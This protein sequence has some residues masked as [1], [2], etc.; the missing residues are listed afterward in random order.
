M[1]TIIKNN[2]HYGGPPGVGIH[3]VIQNAD[4]T[5]TIYLTNGTSYTT[6]PLI[7]A[8][9]TSITFNDDSTIA[10]AMDNGDSFTSDPLNYLPPVVSTDIGKT[11][12]VNENAM[13]DTEFASFECWTKYSTSEGEEPEEPSDQ[14]G[15]IV[16]RLP[17]VT[18]ADAGKF[19]RVNS[20]GTWVAEYMVVGDT[21]A[22]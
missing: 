18:E 19:M 8:Q 20:E 12:I 17:R 15:I 21:T 14:K 16:D 10:I 7:G 5:L 9:I 1:G 11:L 13:W 22:F 2:V 4:Y 3:H 6:D